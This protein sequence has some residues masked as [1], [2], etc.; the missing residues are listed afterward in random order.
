V[1]ERALVRED[2]GAGGRGVKRSEKGAEGK[3]GLGAELP[4]AHLWW[5]WW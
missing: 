1:Q 5:W 3:R 2:K 4:V